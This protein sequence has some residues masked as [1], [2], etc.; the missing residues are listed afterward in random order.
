MT[1]GGE[2]GMITTNKKNLWSKMWSQKD[3][4]K[5]WNAVYERKHLPGFKWLHESFGSN[6]RMTEMQA[7]IGRIQLK[8]LPK[9]SQARRFNAQKILN[10]VRNLPGIRV[11][12]LKCVACDEGCNNEPSCLHAFYKCY[13]FVEGGLSLIHI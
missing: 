4:G 6:Y 11:P 2:G 13:F 1:T 3:H 7:A 9:W 8:R 12:E 10:S 5:S